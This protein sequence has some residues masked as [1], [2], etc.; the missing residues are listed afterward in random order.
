MLPHTRAC[1]AVGLI[2][3]F[4][5][6]PAHDGNSELMEELIVYGR[7]QE[8]IGSADAASEGVVGYDDIRL[9]PM[10][11]VG[12][13]VEAVPGMVATQHSGTGKA[14]QYFL[15]GFNLDHGTDFSAFV[16]GVPINLR[17]HGHGQ[18]Y[19]DLNFMIP[20]LVET[21]TY[22]KGPYSAR[23]GD[24]SSAGSVEFKLYEK[25]DE[26]VV[27]V[28]A[29]AF[30]YYRALAA[31][32]ADARRGTVTAAYDYT[33]YAGPWEIDEDLS[34]TRFHAG[35][36]TEWGQART[37]ISLLGYSGRWNASDQIPLRAVE[38]GLIETRGFIDP[39]LGGKT[40]RLGLTGFVELDSWKATAYF[41]DYDFELFSNFTYLLDDPVD[42]DQFEQVDKRRIY[43]MRLD[44]W[45]DHYQ[46]RVPL[47]LSWGGDVRYDDIDEVGLFSTVSRDRNQAVRQ[48][49]VGVLS[50]SAYSEL[51]VSLSSAL[52]LSLG[53]RADYFAWDVTALRLDNSGSG[54]DLL[55]SPKLNIAYK[56]SDGAEVYLNWGRGFHSND[57]RGNT[58]TVDPVTG[59][60]VD[61]VDPTVKSN[62]AEIGLRIEREERF[63]ATVTAFW[64]AL[65][66][67]LLF[68]GDAGGTEALGASTRLGVELSTFLQATDWLAVNFAYTYTDSQFDEDQGGRKIPGAIG[69][70]GALGLNGAWDNGFF[71]SA[72]VRYLGSAP[73]IEDNSVRASPSLL[74]N[75]GAGYRVG[76]VELRLHVLNLLDSD[77]NDISYYY[78]SRLQQEPLQGVDDIHFRPLEPRSVR[79]SISYHW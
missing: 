43:G 5:A 21:T 30:D 46:W 57:V 75:A 2:G 78:A 17:T 50:V 18:G 76:R 56:V 51:D 25:L 67:E 74:V 11:R 4:Q 13:L 16:D 54:D 31:G 52:R 61:R 66:S 53:L 40:D 23:S 62:G 34:Q 32:S 58:I 55:A 59:E 3:C 26:S 28:T 69:S 71:A 19:L 27:S 15:R 29:G 20:E 63:N 12:E 42:G 1:I 65:D 7:S 72:R 6:A 64:L 33:S 47:T 9:P 8:M 73:L 44:G 70:S 60:P 38:S 48:D 22:R 77:D 14:N 35:Y 36:S 39:D 68:V 41:V 49:E 10:L 37:R 45:H 24:F 79:A